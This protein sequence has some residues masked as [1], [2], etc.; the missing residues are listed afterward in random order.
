MTVYRRTKE[1]GQPWYYDFQLSKV[2]YQGYCL[3]SESG[4]PARSEKE[5]R[6]IEGAERRAAKARQGIARSGIRAGAFT[7]A[8][9]MTLHLDNQVESTPE[10]VANLAPLK[11]VRKSWATSAKDA[12]IE[13]PR[14]FHDV[15]GAYI[16]QVA[17]GTRSSRMIREAAR[18]RDQ[19][20]T[21][22]YIE[23][24]QNETAKAV[25]KAMRPA[26]PKL[27]L[28]SGGRR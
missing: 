20:T 11:S 4:A 7:L 9:A 17:R 15:R 25:E 28:V 8:Q 12:G 21:D 26:G 24:A 3:D 23:I 22:R 5:A 16:T 1:P 19:S 6:D 2:R 18:H 10:H 14:R 27:R 13:K